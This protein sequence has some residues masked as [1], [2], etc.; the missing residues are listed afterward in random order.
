MNDMLVKFNNAG[1]RTKYPYRDRTDPHAALLLEGESSIVAKGSI[2]ANNMIQS[3]AADLRCLHVVVSDDQ[4]KALLANDLALIK[5]V[6]GQA[7]VHLKLEPN[8]YEIEKVISIFDLRF[9]IKGGAEARSPLHSLPK[10]AGSRGL[11][12]TVN[13]GDIEIST[14]AKAFGNSG[15]LDKVDVIVRYVSTS[16]SAAALEQEYSV[17]YDPQ[18]A[19]TVI[20]VP[21]SANVLPMDWAGIITS[22]VRKAKEMGFSSAAFMILPSAC[23]DFGEAVVDFI[24]QTPIIQLLNRFVLVEDNN[25]STIAPASMGD[26]RGFPVTID[27]LAGDTL[28]GMLVGM[29]EK[30][31]TSWFDAGLSRPPTQSRLAGY[32]SNNNNNNS[33]A[34]ISLV[35]C[36]IPLPSSFFATSMTATTPFTRGFK[37]FLVKGLIA[38]VINGMDLLRAIIAPNASGAVNGSGIGPGK[39]VSIL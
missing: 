39:P 22:S 25:D 34:K 31:E 9:F 6:Q 12:L 29:L 36:N 4:Y 18:A 2:E 28:S 20:E 32:D 30:Q 21:I 14:F 19:K 37:S 16:A 17:S 5:Y 10:I 33:G 7:G 1:I 13:I 35:L 11:L 15:F 27:P 3:A 26:S 24:K 38:G 8:Q 23:R